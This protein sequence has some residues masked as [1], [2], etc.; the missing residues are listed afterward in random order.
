MIKMPST[1]PII[2]NKLSSRAT[3]AMLKTRMLLSIEEHIGSFFLLTAWLQIL[4]S[5]LKVTL[6][7]RNISR[8]SP[9]ETMKVYLERQQEAKSI[10]YIQQVIT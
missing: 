6:P 1:I 10:V 8:E 7:A 4:M 3:L 9:Q 2:I 5:T